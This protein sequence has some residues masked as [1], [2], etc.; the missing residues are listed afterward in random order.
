MAACRKEKHMRERLFECLVA[1]RL[2]PCKLMSVWWRIGTDIF[3]EPEDAR[4]MSMD[5]KTIENRVI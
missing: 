3:G 2:E 1:A 5:G 4:C